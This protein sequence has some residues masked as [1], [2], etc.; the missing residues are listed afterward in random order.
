MSATLKPVALVA[1]VCAIFIAL[2]RPWGNSAAPGRS[3]RPTQGRTP[4]AAEANVTD[5]LTNVFYLFDVSA[6]MK[7]DRPDS[8]FRTVVPLLERAVSALRNDDRL[9]KPQL[10]HVGLIGRAGL[11]QQELCRIQV[12]EQGIFLRTDTTASARSLRDCSDRLERI[13]P[14]PTTDISGAVKFASLALQGQQPAVRAVV[15][16]TDLEQELPSTA[17]PAQADL[18]GI[19]V[20]TF[21]AVTDR[22]AANPSSLDTLIASWDAAFRASG[23][24]GTLM[25]LN[26]AF[27]E[28]DLAA[29]LAR[30]STTQ[31]TR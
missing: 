16:F 30:C 19:C 31:S 18:S 9:P 26:A 8:R 27:S 20:A 3:A 7:N 11:S 6:S 13:P 14:T 21:F 4:R 2:I 15:L 1:V 23:A 28:G 25:R 22:A 10:H 12:V 29:F 5:A 24:K 17:K